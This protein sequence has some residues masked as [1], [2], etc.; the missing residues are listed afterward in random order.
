MAVYIIVS[1]MHVHTNI[2]QKQMYENRS[3]LLLST[4]PANKF[5][6][7]TS[8]GRLMFSRTRI[9]FIVRTKE[10]KQI[11]WQNAEFLNVTSE[12][13]AACCCAS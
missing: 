10:N 7:H 3:F 5:P 9:V 6:I 11:V 1:M 12:G 2:K 13:T 4:W 8:T